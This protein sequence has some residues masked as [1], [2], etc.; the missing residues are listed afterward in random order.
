[1]PDSVDRFFQQPTHFH[2]YSSRESAEDLSLQV[3]NDG[4]SCLHYRPSSASFS[5]RACNNGGNPISLKAE[6]ASTAADA[7]GP[8]KHLLFLTLRAEGQLAA[9]GDCALRGVLKAG[10][11]KFTMPGDEVERLL[12]EEEKRTCTH[13]PQVVRATSLVFDFPIDQDLSLSALLFVP[14]ESDSL[15]QLGQFAPK[16]SSMI[17]RK[18]FCKAALIFG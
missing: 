9:A 17:A 16:P 10:Q 8:G 11:L 7:H 14:G 18:P 12:Q 5:G 6:K 2:Q 3:S 15:L 1:L 4:F 13:A